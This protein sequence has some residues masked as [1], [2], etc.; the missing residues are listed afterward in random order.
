MSKEELRTFEL[1][2][3]VSWVLREMHDMIFD[4]P[5][6][7]NPHKTKFRKLTYYEVTN[8][9]NYIEWL[10]AR[11]KALEEVAKNM[12]EEKIEYLKRAILAE[13]KEEDIELL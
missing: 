8:L 7:K 11:N 1:M 6:I 10:E 13:N 9:L 5:I 12:E 4:N 2:S 3:N